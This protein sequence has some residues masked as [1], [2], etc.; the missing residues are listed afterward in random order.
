MLERLGEQHGK[1]EVSEVAAPSV[2][3]GS[4]ASRMAE[5]VVVPS[6]PGNTGG[7]KGPCF[8]CAFDGSE[9]TAIDNTSSNAG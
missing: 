6:K 7:G 4:R 9:E 8:W 2:P 3:K 1:S 5:G